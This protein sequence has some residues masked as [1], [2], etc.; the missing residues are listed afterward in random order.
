MLQVSLYHPRKS[1]GRSQVHHLTRTILKLDH[2]VPGYAIATHCQ[3]SIIRSGFS[4]SGVGY[5]SHTNI[6]VE[7]WSLES[8][9]YAHLASQTCLSLPWKANQLLRVLLSLY[10]K[11]SYCPSGFCEASVLDL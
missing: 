3:G 1:W 10:I 6:L 11:L 7:A 4:G 8:D 5:L 2:P 9:G